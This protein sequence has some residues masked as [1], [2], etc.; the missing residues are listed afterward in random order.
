MA[1]PATHACG[2]Q[3]LPPVATLQPTAEPRWPLCLATLPPPCDRPASGL[4]HDH[5][6]G[7]PFPWCCGVM[8]GERGRHTAGPDPVPIT[9]TL[10]LP[11]AWDSHILLSVGRETFP[12]LWHWVFSLHP[13]PWERRFCMIKSGLR[14]EIPTAVTLPSETQASTVQELRAEVTDAADAPMGLQ[15]LSRRRL[16]G[17]THGKGKSNFS[18]IQRVKKSGYCPY[19]L[20]WA[21]LRPDT[22][23]PFLGGSKPTGGEWAFF[24]SQ[25]RSI[26]SFFVVQKLR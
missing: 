4:C 26:S 5:R 15:T 14:D 10:E 2:D 11:W 13:R 7:A 3:P 21:S 1:G 17:R 16:G 18:K 12:G 8:D 6:Y 23:N 9:N 19:P 20:P 24:S 22:D 25:K